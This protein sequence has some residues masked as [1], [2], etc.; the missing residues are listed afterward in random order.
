MH[1]FFLC[2]QV[3][4][5]IHISYEKILLY[6]PICFAA[7]RKIIGSNYPFNS[8][9]RRS[10]YSSEITWWFE[11]F[12]HLLSQKLLLCKLSN[13]GG[14]TKPT[15]RTGCQ[16]TYRKISKIINIKATPPYLQYFTPTRFKIIFW[17]SEN[18]QRSTM[19]AIKGKKS[20]KLHIILFHSFWFSK[21][22]STCT[23]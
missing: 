13:T 19:L 10:F 3:F 21:I 8:N 6:T 22:L 23:G 9:P 7:L 18:Y 11:V 20:L 14:T 5:K 16:T 4:S 2:A 1:C 17:N 15:V 12:P